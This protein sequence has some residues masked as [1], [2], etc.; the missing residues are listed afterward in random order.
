MIAGLSSWTWRLA[1]VAGAAVLVAACGQPTGG[2][3]RLKA[4]PEASLTFPDSKQLSDGGYDAQFTVEGEQPAGFWR[5]IGSDATIEDIRDFYE[6]E[7]ADAGW[8][9]QPSSRST[10][11]L[12]A[13]R[14]HQ[15]DLAFRLGFLNTEEWHQRLDGSDQFPTLYEIHLSDGVETRP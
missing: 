10:T 4:L 9:R 14:W 1:A 11:E 6:G 12:E 13:H 2:Y 15:G 3:D 7:L 5:I 8:V